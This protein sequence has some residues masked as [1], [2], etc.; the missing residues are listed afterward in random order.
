[1]AGGGAVPIEEVL[2]LRDW[3][4]LRAVALRA[5]GARLVDHVL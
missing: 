1:V 4:A 3:G 5:L 2:N